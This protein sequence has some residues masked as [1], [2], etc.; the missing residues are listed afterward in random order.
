MNRDSIIKFVGVIYSLLWLSQVPYLFPHPFQESEGIRDLAT[1]AA[2]SPDW[3][4]QKSSIK[5]K[6]EDELYTSMLIGL[7][8]SWIKSTIFI[9][10]GLVSG[11][12]L[13]QRR[14]AGYFL[15]FSLSILIIG[16]K[17]LHLMRYRSNTF[18][19]DYYKFLLQ[20]M[21][22]RT[23]HDFL[24]QLVLL[25]TVVFLM[26]ISVTEKL[27]PPTTKILSR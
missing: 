1:E 14:K 10:M 24:M 18:S 16:I 21:P 15:T 7:R 5:D 22:L 4:K 2:Q 3:I 11:C 12:L 23:I 8:I 25:S 26:Y 17:F 9:V 20:H 19:L 27:P 6:T 13:I